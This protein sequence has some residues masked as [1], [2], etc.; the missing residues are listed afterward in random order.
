MGMGDDGTFGDSLTVESLKPVFDTA[1]ANGLELNV[2]CFWEKG[3][4]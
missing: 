4:K 2:L 3:M 1:M